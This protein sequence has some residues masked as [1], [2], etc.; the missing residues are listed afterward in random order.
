MTLPMLMAPSR[1]FQGIFFLSDLHLHSQL[2]MFPV[3]LGHQHTML[4]LY[5]CPSEDAEYSTL[6]IKEV[7]TIISS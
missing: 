5:L 1:I 4:I 3:G 7:A 2:K 6:I